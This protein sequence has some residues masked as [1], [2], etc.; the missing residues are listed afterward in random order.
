MYKI[1]LKNILETIERRNEHGP[2]TE[3]NYLSSVIKMR[4]TEL[5]MTLSETTQN[6]CSEAFLSKIER[7]LMSPINERV[8]L[9]CERLDLDYSTLINLESNDRIDKLL[10]YY[11][12]DEYDKILEIPD[13]TCEDVFIAQDEIIKAYKY[14]IKKEY[15]NLHLCIIG[16]DNVKECLC[17]TELFAL[18]LVV[19]EI[20][21][22][23]LQFSKALEYIN[24][25]DKLNFRSNKYN[26]FIKER[27]FILSC[28]MELSNVNYLFDDIRRDFHL[29]SINKQFALILH[30]HETLSSEE[31]Y[32]YLLD[33]GKDYVPK[34]L[35]EEYKYAKILLLTKLNKHVDAMKMVIESNVNHI[36]FATIYAFNLF[37]YSCEGNFEKDIKNYK[38]TLISYIKLC[39]QNAGETYHI[40]FLRLMQFEIDKSSPDIIC[41]YIKNQLLK[42]LN[43]FSFPLY[44]EYIRNRYCLLLG[45]LCRYKDAYLYLLESKMHL[46]K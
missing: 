30:Y 16:L 8:E 2:I 38:S 43:D 14:F 35:I 18:L 1:Y 27:K 41:N 25:I 19:F 34:S 32:Q 22:N 39:D 4:R 15:K 10:N 9:L 33:M 3:T 11:I 44:D 45:K 29:F 42:E 28:K 24:L 36:K 23:T 46:K 5:K 37:M 26:L 31:A 7:N 13:K 12:K 20:N 21:L 17:D 6:I 40:A